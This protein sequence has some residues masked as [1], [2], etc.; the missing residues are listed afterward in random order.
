MRQLISSSVDRDI[1]D[2][3]TVALPSPPGLSPATWPC[4]TNARVR[5]TN[6]LYSIQA[7]P[8]GE[9]PM[10]SV[11]PA[12]G[13]TMLFAS[14]NVPLNALTIT[15]IHASTGIEASDYNVAANLLCVPLPDDIYLEPGETLEMSSTNVGLTVVVLDPFIGYDQSIIP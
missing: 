14:S 13:S 10:I 2:H 5:I 15:L 7:V 3:I 11:V 8:G 1:F 9:F 12:A 6:I 4:P